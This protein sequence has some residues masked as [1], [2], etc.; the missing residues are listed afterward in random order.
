[1]SKRKGRSPVGFLTLITVFLVISLVSI[2]TMALFATGKGGRLT[3]RSGEYVILYSDAWRLS[4]QRLAQTDACIA[5]SA[6]GGLFD[7]TFPDSVSEIEGVRCRREGDSFIIT[8]TTPVDGRTAVYWEICAA[9]F[10]S[11]PRGDYEITARRSVPLDGE[12]E[13]EEETLNVWQ[14]VLSF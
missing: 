2:G 4:E 10:P 3:D 9:A 13:Q 5:A 12:E 8:C 7:L 14:G 11:D 6:S 1:M